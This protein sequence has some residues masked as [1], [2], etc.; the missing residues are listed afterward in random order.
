VPG[1]IPYW[2]AGG[3][4]D[5]V[6]EAIF[7]EPLVLLGEDGAPFFEPG[8]PVSFLLDGPA[9][10]NNHIHVLRPNALVDRRFLAYALNAADYS[11]YISGST[12]DKLTQEEMWQIRI[13]EL[14]LEDQR[15]VADYLD[16]ETA[17]IDDL[18]ARRSGL[19]D[20]SEERLGAHREHLIWEGNRP[21]HALRRACSLIRDGTHQPPQRVSEGYALLSVRNLADGR[22]KL[23]EDDSKIS[24]SD[25]RQLTKTWRVQ[26]GDVALAVVGTLGKVGVVDNLPPVAL[27]R[28]LAILR[29]RSDMTDARYL[30]HAVAAP[31]FGAALWSTVA[32]SAQPGVYLE[33]LASLRIPLPPLSQQRALA[34]E[35]DD[36][37]EWRRRV[38]RA[39]ESQLRL[40]RERR[41]ALITTAVTGQLDIPEAA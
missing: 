20:L 23:R 31:S 38:A 25:Y 5:H 33:T 10:V 17:R 40:L 21:R 16:R 12:R 24:E 22:L 30:Y 11:A 37:E 9:W 29:A 8:R 41:Q 4:I 3:V 6:A 32:F 1:P 7:D 39:V 34:R 19:M 15:C 36:A 14:E 27:Q 2:G 35:L 26:P 18:I 13:P 28:S